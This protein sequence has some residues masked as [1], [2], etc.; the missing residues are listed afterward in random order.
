M[1]IRH[2]ND[3][4]GVIDI[5]NVCFSR[6]SKEK[7]FGARDRLRNGMAR[8]RVRAGGVALQGGSK[9]GERAGMCGRLR[10]ASRRWSGARGSV[11]RRAARPERDWAAGPLPP[12]RARAPRSH[13]P[14]IDVIFILD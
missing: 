6:V 2:G 8:G 10:R 9:C 3:K 4:H 11:V 13:P 1:A 14:P 12:A 5:E 7:R